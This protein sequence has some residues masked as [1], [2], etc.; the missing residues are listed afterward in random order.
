MRTP[1]ADI[2]KDRGLNPSAVSKMCGVN[3]GQVYQ[4]VSGQA[5]IPGRHIV[6]LTRGLGLTTE[7]A[8]DLQAQVSLRGRAAHFTQPE[9]PTTI[10]A[11]LLIT[12][13][14]GLGVPYS[15]AVRKVAEDSGIPPAAVAMYAEGELLVATRHAIPLAR[16]LSPAEPPGWRGV[17]AWELAADA[18][19][20]GDWYRFRERLAGEPVTPDEA[21]AMIDEFEQRDR[22]TP[23]LPAEAFG[24]L[25]ATE[26]V[27]PIIA[28]KAAEFYKQRRN[29]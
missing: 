15:K 28:E 18:D 10:V 11:F 26:P 7:Q 2:L 4:W 27:H 3:P 6:A 9:P 29:Q 12:N 21:R 1:L 16:A 24:V 14:V 23:M 17:L 8:A 22:S 19:D 5:P 25:E 20:Q 13:Y